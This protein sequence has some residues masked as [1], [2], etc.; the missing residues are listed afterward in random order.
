[1]VKLRTELAARQAGPGVG[2]ADLASMGEKV[3]RK[4]MLLQATQARS[5]KLELENEQLRDDLRREEH[6][7]READEKRKQAV[8]ELHAH[9][10]SMLERNVVQLVQTKVEPESAALEAE[11]DKQKIDA[12]EEEMEQLK[13]KLVNTQ[14]ELS[15]ARD[16]AETAQA[17]LAESLALNQSFVRKSP[18]VVGGSEELD[19]ESLPAET[20]HA[21]Q[22]Q[23]QELTNYVRLLEDR[24]SAQ[25]RS[26]GMNARQRKTEAH[27]AMAE[28]C[29]HV[30]KQLRVAETKL[31]R[32]TSLLE[33]TFNQLRE[34][35]G[36]ADELGARSAQLEEEVG[37]AAKPAG[38]CDVHLV[39]PRMHSRLSVPPPSSL[40]PFGSPLTPP[41]V[42]GVTASRRGCSHGA[43][44]PQRLARRRG[45]CR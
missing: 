11:A 2:M 41:A 45:E 12:L 18:A 9:A 24:L 6:R 32:A 30:T 15:A 1:M 20:Y 34:A 23:R 42:K 39:H 38:P 16:E 5:E 37:P 31:G 40:K 29:A 3:K 43:D 33:P 21:L 13:L 10:A 26:E 4:E 27:T 7:R 36:M 22:S 35:Q 25:E 17:K 19:S 44:R 8:A 14:N 28:R